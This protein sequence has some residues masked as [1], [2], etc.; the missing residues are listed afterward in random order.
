MA[1]ENTAEMRR[2]VALDRGETSPAMLMFDAM[3]RELRSKATSYISMR[4]LASFAGTSDP[5]STMEAVGYF[6]GDRVPLLE[7]CYE[8]IDE[9]DHG[10]PLEPSA[11]FAALEEGILRHR[12]V[13]GRPRG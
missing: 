9:D 1:N 11:V 3:V 5:V 7:A 12:P 6:L 8:L 2:R 13:Q 10:I 4:R